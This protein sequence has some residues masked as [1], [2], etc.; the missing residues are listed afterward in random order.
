MHQVSRAAD[1][2]PTILF[3]ATVVFD[4]RT[5]IDSVYQG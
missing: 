1:G 5:G 2:M 3:Y 4:K